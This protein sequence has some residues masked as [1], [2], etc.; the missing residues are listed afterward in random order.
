MRLLDALNGFDAAVIIDATAPG[1]DGPG[2]IRRLSPAALGE[3]WNSTS[4]HDLDLPTA[5]ALGRMVGMKIPQDIVLWGVE[6][7]DMETFT[8]EPTPAVARAIPLLV[9]R[10]C[11]ELGVTFQ[12]PHSEPL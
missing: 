11:T 12:Q 2:T 6:G 9:Q 4:L 8:E 1:P 10:V 3:S 7:Q 5:L